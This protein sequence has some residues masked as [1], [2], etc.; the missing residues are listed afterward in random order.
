VKARAAVPLL[1]SILMAGSAAPAAAQIGLGLR[2]G[3]GSG[4]LGQYVAEVQ[5]RVRIAGPLHLAGAFEV[6]VSGWACGGGGLNDLR[7]NYDG[8]AISAGPMV[9]MID[10]GRLWIAARATAGRFDRGHKRLPDWVDEDHLILGAGLDVEL[11]VI[12]PVSMLASLAHRRV[13]DEQY[14]DLIGEY[15]RVTSFTMGIGVAFGR[16]SDAP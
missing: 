7:C 4:H 5:G 1:A 13:L 16:N 14:D 6:L 15:P 3:A 8:Y 9:P 10:T 11:R 2:L 12:G